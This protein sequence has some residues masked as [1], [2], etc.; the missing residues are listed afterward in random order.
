MD[1]PLRV[2]WIDTLSQMDLNHIINELKN[3]ELYDYAD[4]LV[5]DQRTDAYV[6]GD[7]SQ[8]I[9]FDELWLSTISSSD[10]PTPRVVNPRVESRGRLLHKHITHFSTRG[11]CHAAHQLGLPLI[12]SFNGSF[13]SSGPLPH[14]GCNHC[15]TC[16][17]NNVISLR[18]FMFGGQKNDGVSEEIRLSS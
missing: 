18:T 17:H 9:R 1:P 8:F 2:D 7:D 14:C 10:A 16:F 11:T 13:S 4:T 6:K 15:E 12:M 3:Y 5:S